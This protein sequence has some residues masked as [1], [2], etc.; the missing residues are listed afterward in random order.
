[1]NLQGEATFILSIMVLMMFNAKTNV[2]GKNSIMFPQ[3]SGVFINEY[4]LI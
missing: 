4:Y 2:E 1:M 3:A